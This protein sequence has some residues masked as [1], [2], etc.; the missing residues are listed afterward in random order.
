MKKLTRR[1]KEF[2]KRTMKIEM[3]PWAKAYT[4]DIK[5]IYTEL[6]LDKIENQP[7]GPEGKK[8]EDYKELFECIDVQGSSTPGPSHIASKDSFIRTGPRDSRKKAKA[9]KILFKGDPGYR[10]NNIFT[11]SGMGLGNR[12]LYCSVCSVYFFL[13][14]KLAKPGESIENL[15]IQQNPVVAALNIGDK[16]LKSIIENFGISCLIILEGLDEHDIQKCSHIGDVISGRQ[17]LGCN[18]FVT[19]R[20]HNISDCEEYF[21]TVVKVQGFTKNRAADYLTKTLNDKAKVPDVLSFNANNFAQ[22]HNYASPML[23]LFVG[24]L[25]NSGE[26]DLSRT[27]VN[28]GEVYTRLI[29][30]L[31]RKYTVRK[32][33]AF[34]QEGF[35]K[36][37]TSLGKLALKILATN[38][39]HLQRGDALSDV[40]EDCFEYGLIIGHEDFRLLSDPTADVVVTFVHSSLEDFLGAFYFTYAGDREIEQ[41]VENLSPLNKNALLLQFILWLISDLCHESFFKFSRRRTIYRWMK[42]KM[43][44]SLNQ[45]QLHLEEFK[46]IHP[47]FSIYDAVKSLSV[48]LL[49]FARDVFSSCDK[50][51]EI[52]LVSDYPVGIV[53]KF[54]LETFPNLQI[55]CNLP[56]YMFMEMLSS[57]S[58]LVSQSD[59][60]VAGTNKRS[61][62]IATILSHY[63][64]TNTHPSLCLLA[65]S[66]GELNLSPYMYRCIS[67]LRVFGNDSLLKLYGEITFLAR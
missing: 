24:I 8:I 66:E 36:V 6:T 14:M 12:C 25:T 27:I 64:D 5:E 9:K 26:I 49:N 28:L 42:Q 67:K 51:R 22:N 47:S 59:V 31:Y 45:A 32:G 61:A 57:Y 44:K 33:I 7:T 48:D 15:I 38:T 60:I 23:L 16:R 52:Y 3:A 21:R 46:M 18:I 40:G 2:Y 30:C 62:N 41:P 1:I 19:S 54:F 53:R 39:Y 63:L 65:E 37:L 29:R 50:T 20:P 11:K 56:Q 4:V 55:I 35:E 58:Q 13:T 43:V 34:K 10:E 17:L